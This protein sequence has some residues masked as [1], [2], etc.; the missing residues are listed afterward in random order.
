MYCP[1]S[2]YTSSLTEPTYPTARENTLLLL[3]AAGRCVSELKKEYPTISFD[4]MKEEDDAYFDSLG[5]ERESDEKVAGRARELFAWLKDRPET[6][7][8]VVRC[9][10]SVAFLRVSSSFLSCL[11]LSPFRV[12]PPFLLSLLPFGCVPTRF[13]SRRPHRQ[14][15]AVNIIAMAPRLGNF[16]P[17]KS[18]S[19]SPHL[20][21]DTHNANN[22]S[23]RTS[24]M[25]ATR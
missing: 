13:V 12:R 11:V 3:S 1:N 18:L 19:T 23:L 14:C 15:S 8:A 10:F 2:P 25:P 24:S 22:T 5:D 7:I 20:P 4:A 6:N 17:V 21:T 9:V 16:Y